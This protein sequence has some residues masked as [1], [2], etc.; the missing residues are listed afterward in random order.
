MWSTMIVLFEKFNNRIIKF[1]E[2]DS[3]LKLMNK[4]YEIEL[5]YYS[6]LKGKKK[7]KE[8]TY[9]SNVGRKRIDYSI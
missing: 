4:V 7:M 3:A 1:R 2:L 6:F 8:Y 5:T 9:S